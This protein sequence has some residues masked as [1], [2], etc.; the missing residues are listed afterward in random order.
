MALSTVEIFLA[1]IHCCRIRQ[2]TSVLRKIW[3]CLAFLD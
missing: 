3:G 2:W 1:I